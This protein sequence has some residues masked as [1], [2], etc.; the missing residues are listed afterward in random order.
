MRQHFLI[1]AVI[2]TGCGPA[3]NMFDC[4]DEAA[5]ALIEAN[6]DLTRFPI[7]GRQSV[8]F[9]DVALVHFEYGAANDCPA[10]CF[11]SHY[12]ALVVAGQ[13]K[14]LSF[15]FNS[16]AE[17]LFPP[18]Q[19]CS[20]VLSDSS[21][22]NDCDMPAYDEPLLADAGFRAWAA[23]IEGDGDEEMRWCANDLMYGYRTGSLPR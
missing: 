17:Q 9:D 5:C 21:N 11:Y 7:E 14:P 23:D 6:H 10:G 20:P 1:V 15:T 13:E 16:E 22:P 3:D 12:C 19:Y 18:G 8:V 2:A 4:A